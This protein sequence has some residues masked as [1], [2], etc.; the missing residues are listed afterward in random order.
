MRRIRDGREVPGSLA[1]LPLE[2]LELIRYSEPD[3][4]GWQPGGQGCA[5]QRCGCSAARCC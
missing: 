4:P 5:E 2:V 1:G 3:V